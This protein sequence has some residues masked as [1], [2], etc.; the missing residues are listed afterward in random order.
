MDFLK[1]SSS[2]S[3]V[4]SSSTLNVL[5]STG[6]RVDNALSVLKK[7]KY[8]FSF[9]LVLLV[10]Y[11]PAGA[12]KLNSHVEGVLKNYA[13]KF[14]YI[15]LLAYLL[16]DSVA[17]AVVVSLIITLGSLLLRKLDSEHFVDST[18]VIQNAENVIEQKAPLTLTCKEASCDEA[19]SV[20]SSSCPKQTMDQDKMSGVIC[21]ETPNLE[22]VLNESDFPGYVQYQTS[23]DYDPNA[24]ISDVQHE[25]VA[26]S[27]SYTVNRLGDEHESV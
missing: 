26:A 23:N 22:P 9:L 2:S 10:L 3:S 8:V 27:N 11:A 5:S 6:R 7:N 21:N 1:T 4:S 19:R 15:F 14:V 25:G 12:P 24:L 13:A 18:K 17:V 16:T 20:R